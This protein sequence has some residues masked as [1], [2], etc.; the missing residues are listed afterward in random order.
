[1]ALYKLRFFCDYG[2]GCIW[3]DNDKA[4]NEFGV[5][6]NSDTLPISDNLKEKI[7]E[8]ENAFQESID[9]NDPSSSLIWND[10]QK[11]DFAER[12][13]EI[14]HKLSSELGENFEIRKEK[15]L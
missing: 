13:S 9:W 4:V 3:S 8:L 12:E 14:Y 6:V 7:K 11:Q 2:G 5:M 10:I 1:M 15:S